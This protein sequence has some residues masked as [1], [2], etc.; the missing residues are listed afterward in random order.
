MVKITEI[1]GMLPRGSFAD[2]LRLLVA[3]NGAGRFIAHQ[4]GEL[5]KRIEITPATPLDKA[6]L[7]IDI[8]RK[9]G[10]EEDQAGSG[11]L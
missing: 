8:V 1:M 4:Q 9:G 11:K 2:L 3:D 5:K 6:S 10:S 7:I